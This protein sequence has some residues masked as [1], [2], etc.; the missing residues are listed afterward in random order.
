MQQKSFV[1]APLSHTNGAC[2]PIFLHQ[3][4]LTTVKQTQIS[5]TLPKKTKNSKHADS[6]QYYKGHLRIVSFVPFF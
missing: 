5:I 3:T 4:D 6:N 1:L 2:I